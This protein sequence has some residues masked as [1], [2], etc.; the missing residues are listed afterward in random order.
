MYKFKSRVTGDLIMLEPNGRQILKILGRTEEADR[1]RG[2]L[3]P[4]DMPG[5]IA[6][7][8]AAIAADEQHRKEAMEQALEEGLPPP[9]FEGISLRQRAT[10]FIAMIERC[11]EANKEIVW[12][13]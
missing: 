4:A 9:S 5:A 1:A 6:A 12:G 2:I 10:P 8:H 3:E 13:V 11:L 7:L